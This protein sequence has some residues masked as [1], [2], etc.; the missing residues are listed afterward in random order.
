MDHTVLP[1]NSYNYLSQSGPR[2]NGNKVILNNPEVSK[3]KPQP[4]DDV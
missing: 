1:N 2:S 3:S 4:S